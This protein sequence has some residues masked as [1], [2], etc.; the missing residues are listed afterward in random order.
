[1]SIDQT[2][3]IDLLG[4]KEGSN[5]LDLFIT[6]HLSW[7]DQTT[8]EHIYK[9]QEKLNSYLAALE[10]GEI[11]QKYPEHKGKTVVITVVG[12]HP[13]SERANEFYDKAS[14]IVSGAGFK[15]VFK[16]SP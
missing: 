2:K 6:D 3:V 16:L 15:L 11:E 9:L 12:K 5:T 7:D 13:L 8:N 14:A 4:S 10:G 1:M